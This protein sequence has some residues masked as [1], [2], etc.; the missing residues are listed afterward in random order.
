MAPQPDDFETPLVAAEFEDLPGW[1]A[2]DAV[3]ALAAFR[4][5]CEK[6]VASDVDRPV[7]SRASYGGKIADWTPACEAAGGDV[8]TQD[9]ARAYFEAWFSPLEVAPNADTSKLTGY[10]E[11][12][13]M[14]RRAPEPGFDAAIPGPPDD[15]VS[16]NLGDFDESLGTRRFWGQ[17]K[18][19]RLRLYPPRA[20]IVDDP[21]RALGF[22][23]PGDVFY[24]QIQGSG[25]VSFPDGETIRAAFAAHN[26]RP[27]GSIARYLIDQGEITRSQAGMSG[28]KAWMAA[29]GSLRAQHAMNQNPR[30]VWFR[31]ETLD[32][33]LGPKGAQGV[34]LTPMASMAVDPNFHPYGAPIFIDTRAPVEPG[35]WE[36]A[37]FQTL[38]IAQDTGGA[39]TGVR[40]G[41]LFFGW[42]DEAGGRASSMNHE[43]RMWTLLP[44]SLAAQIA[45]QKAE[46]EAQP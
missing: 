16:V 39:I 32:P 6:W 30:Y 20:D 4:K 9:A 22:A 21:A 33:A 5:S 31:A 44:K 35:D 46:I 43:M 8:A 28:V 41:D 40:R 38:V 10:F 1:D 12:E 23:D 26:N 13:L 19:G 18:G 7:T 34:P 17:V 15:L 11:P 24:L 3:S 27:F 37:P 14:A 42:G 36:G 29:A 2:A 25:R 45:P